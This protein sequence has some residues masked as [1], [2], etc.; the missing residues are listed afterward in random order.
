MGERTYSPVLYILLMQSQVD[1]SLDESISLSIHPFCLGI[2]L[3]FDVFVRNVA[4]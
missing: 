2:G 3:L 1:T 4:T